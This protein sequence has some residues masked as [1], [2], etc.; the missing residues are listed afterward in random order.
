LEEAAPFA[1]ASFT[2]EV[3]QTG[4][5]SPQ[6]RQIVDYHDRWCAAHSGRPLA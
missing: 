1:T 6:F 3:G 4:V 5:L 2:Q